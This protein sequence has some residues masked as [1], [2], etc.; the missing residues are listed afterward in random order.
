MQI[1]W[2]AEAAGVSRSGYY[3]WL[4]DTDKRRELE[5]QDR[6]DF[7]LILEAY[8]FRGIDKGAKG[9]HMRLL[10]MTPSILMNEKKIRRLSR[11]YGLYCLIRKPNPNRIRQKQLMAGKVSRNIIGRRFNRFNPR[12]AF[13]TDITYIHYN[14]GKNL[15]YLSVIRDVCT[16]EIMSHA[17]SVSM[18]EDFVLDTVKHFINYYGSEIKGNAILHSDQGIHYR[19]I[20]FKE[21]LKDEKLRQSMSRKANCWDNAPQESFFG[22]MKD[23]IGD[24]VRKCRTFNEVKEAIKG[25]MDY[26]NEERGQWCLAKLTPKEYYEYR[27]TG[28]YPFTTT[29]KT[30]NSHADVKNIKERTKEN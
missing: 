11:K 29:K 23:E 4:A 14:Y 19:C 20:S 1:K 22:H 8:Q 16:H 27:K 3:K 10:R 26:Y 5:E 21:L 2:L 17:A 7:E 9:I 25:Y 12:E 6:R 24:R 30:R 18:A 28:I 15:C 13:T